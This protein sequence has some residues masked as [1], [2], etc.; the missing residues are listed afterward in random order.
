MMDFNAED[1]GSCWCLE[2][3]LH[4]VHVKES[5]N[6]RPIIA[7]ANAMSSLPLMASLPVCL[8]AVD[9]L[10]LFSSLKAL[11][12]LR[13]KALRVLSLSAAETSE[14]CC[15]TPVICSTFTDTCLLT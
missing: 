11:C 5:S 13:L 10:V 14:G 9:R 8:C 4:I 1:Q 7:S 6:D 12:L 3:D 15:W 2:T